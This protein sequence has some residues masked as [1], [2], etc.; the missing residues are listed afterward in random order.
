MPLLRSFGLSTLMVLVSACGGPGQ[1]AAPTGT[2]R[3]AASGTPAVTNQ[4]TTPAATSVPS[5]AATPS[6]APEASLDPT[7]SD[8]GIVARVTLSNDTFGER[9]GTY[10]VIG[11][12]ADASFCPYTVGDEEFTAV[13][14]HDDAA[15]GEIFQFGVTVLTSQVPVTDGVTSDIDGRISFDFHSESGI[16]TLYIGDA[17]DDGHATITATRA[18]TT[19]TFDF[20]GA[21]KAGAQFTGQMIC[22]D[23]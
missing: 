18:G 14:Y 19:L 1:T 11:V 4:P 16:G 9:D 20:V 15:V 2:P 12:K 13:A 21:T 8:A 23:A 10:D 3:A 17:P 5:A 7:Q 6:V 22:A